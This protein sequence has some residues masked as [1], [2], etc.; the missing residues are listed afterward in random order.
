M[1]YRDFVRE[2]RTS[3][4]YGP[5]PHQD[6][7]AAEIESAL[8]IGNQTIVIN[9]PPS[10]GATTICAEWLFEWLQ[11]ERPHKGSMLHYAWGSDIA[12]ATKNRVGHRDFLSLGIDASDS[13]YRGDVVVID[14]V[15]MSATGSS[16]RLARIMQRMHEDVPRKKTPEGLLIIVESRSGPDDVS[17]QMMSRKTINIVLPARF[18]RMHPRAFD[19]DARAEGDPLWPNRFGEAEIGFWAVIMGGTL[20][21]YALQQ[22]SPAERRMD[23]A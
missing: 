21:S 19:R 17:I 2:K 18:E 3:L 11:Q 20:A 14:S 6:L 22:R 23:S 4:G 9:L 12:R 1:L 8:D 10:H 7:M 13:G 16:T 5:A 15:S